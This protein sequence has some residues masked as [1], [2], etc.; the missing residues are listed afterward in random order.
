MQQDKPNR[1]ATTTNLYSK[2]H[3]NHLYASEVHDKCGRLGAYLALI[4]RCGCDSKLSPGP[5]D[6]TWACRCQAFCRAPQ[7]LAWC[8][9]LGSYQ[10]T[11]LFPTSCHLVHFQS[12]PLA[13]LLEVQLHGPQL[14]YLRHLKRWWNPSSPHS[15]PLFSKGVA[16]FYTKLNIWGSLGL[17]FDYDGGPIIENGG[18][19]CLYMDPPWRD[20]KRP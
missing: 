8:A 20:S 11:A 13:G 1:S 17:N 9:C 14:T 15:P 10:Q 3:L 12:L 7:H 2:T 16:G 5:A 6:A 4:P 19:I 18:R